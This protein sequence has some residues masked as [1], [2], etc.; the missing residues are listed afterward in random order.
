MDAALRSFLRAHLRQG[1]L[2]L[3]L[4]AAAMSSG[5]KLLDSWVHPESCQTCDD[6]RP[7]VPTMPPGSQPKAIVTFWSDTLQTA[8][9]PTHGGQLTP[10]LVG[11]V[12]L[13]TAGD[14]SMIY[15]GSCTVKLYDDR[16]PQGGA[17][18]CIEVWNFDK[19]TLKKLATQTAM[20]WGYT[21]F[22]PTERCT[23][24]VNKA[25][26][27]VEFHP[28]GAPYPLYAAPATLY[29]KY[30]EQQRQ[31]W[32]AQE[33][34]RQAYMQHVAQTMPQQQPMQQQMPQQLQ[35]GMQMPMQQPMVQMPVQQP[36]Q[37]PVQMPVQVPVQAPVQ[38]PVQQQSMQQPVAFPGMTP[39]AF[40]QSP[41]QPQLPATGFAQGYQ[42]MPAGPSM[43]PASPG[44][45]VQ[46]YQVPVQVLPANVHGSVP[47][48]QVDPSAVPMPGGRP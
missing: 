11:R 46:S 24:A 30:S 9:D 16:P 43:Q 35:P 19:D 10:G 13:F 12:L 1:F 29:M 38:V 22:L 45:P 31:Q 36:I 26:M 17:P 4:G 33:A 25:H 37:M 41:Q 3:A 23:P 8:P 18:V 39:A 28:E 34:Y 40:A 6:G 7:Q 14:T 15:E 20:G 44:Q 5:C 48:I 42:P 21:L 27:Q 2:A 47:L 32:L